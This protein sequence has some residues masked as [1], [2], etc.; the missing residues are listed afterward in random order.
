[1]YWAGANIVVLAIAA[2]ICF[3]KPRPSTIIFSIGEAA[4]VRFREQ[5]IPAK[6]VNLSLESGVVEPPRD[7]GIVIHDEILIEAAGFPP[8]AAR[9]ESITRQREGSVAFRF[10]HSLRAAARD[11]LIVKLYASGEY[12]QEIRQ[13]HIWAIIGGLWTRAFGRPAVA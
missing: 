3:E 12:S 6:L 2:L 1:M 11:R 9:V 7:P 4:Q 10:T 8:L 5:S 13:I